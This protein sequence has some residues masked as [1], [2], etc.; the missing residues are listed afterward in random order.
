MRGKVNIAGALVLMLVPA[1]ALAHPGAE[2]VVGF[3]AGFSHPWTGIDHIVT[4]LV[5][6]V[7]LGRAH[8]RVVPALSGVTVSGIVG[9]ALLFSGQIAFT[10]GFIVA[11]LML[12]LIG[13]SLAAAL[14]RRPVWL[15][16]R[17]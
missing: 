11:M 13:A 12:L 17:S 7:W 6:G 3:F 9:G 16:T 8:P 5:A 15:I 10:A 2:H 4:M 14:S 1:L